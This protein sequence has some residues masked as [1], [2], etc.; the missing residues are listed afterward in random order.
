MSHWRQQSKKIVNVMIDT[1]M[2]KKCGVNRDQQRV[3]YLASGLLVLRL[4]YAV[5]V[6]KIF[7]VEIQK[8]QTT[9][10]ALCLVLFFMRVHLFPVICKGKIQAKERVMMLWSSFIY[11][12]RIDGVH[13][14][15]K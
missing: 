2:I 12:L 9:Q 4:H 14:T 7:L 15:T 13:I 11:F 3:K 8:D 1:G 5:K 6:G 10:V